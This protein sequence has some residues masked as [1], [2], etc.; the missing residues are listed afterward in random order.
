MHPHDPF[1]WTPVRPRRNR[2]GCA[3]ASRAGLKPTRAD[4]PAWALR[5]GR[6]RPGV[7]DN[8]DSRTRRS[9]SSRVRSGRWVSEGGA[10]SGRLGT[11][12]A[13]RRRR[14][15]PAS[16]P[17]PYRD[18]IEVCCWKA[19][20]LERRAAGFVEVTKLGFGV[21]PFREGLPAPHAGREIPEDREVVPRLGER[22]RQGAHCHHLQV[23]LGS[24]D[25]LS[26]EAHGGWQDDIGVP[27][28]GRPREVLHDERV[29]PGEGP[30]QPRQILMVVE[31]ISAGPVNQLYL[32]VG[33]PLAVEVE[34]GARIQKH[35]GDARARNECLDP[36]LALWK[37]W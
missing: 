30:S 33:Q 20:G 1:A 35:V 18:D 15:V 8:R 36:V 29:D 13:Y 21:A 22:L 7:R 28:A 17:R 34:R 4:R 12:G 27:R 9:S 26:L 14:R 6:A 10:Q 23:G 5:S 11:C 32:R 2:A 37:R 31:W 19:A 24:A 25:I 16:R 3:A